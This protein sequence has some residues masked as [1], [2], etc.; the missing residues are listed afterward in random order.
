MALS[1]MNGQQV[2]DFAAATSQQVAGMSVSEATAALGGQVYGTNGLTTIYTFP[3]I[4]TKGGVPVTLEAQ[5]A[6]QMWDYFKIT[7]AA[8]IS[9][10]GTAA[11]G[12]SAWAQGVLF[13]DPALSGTLAG[14]GG[15]LAM[16]MP[17]AVTVM[18]PLL[19]VAIGSDIG[20]S[21]YRDNPVLWG[22][23]S[24]A[25]SDF[26]YNSKEVIA[27]VV[28]KDGQTYVSKAA[29]EALKQV[30]EQEGIGGD[31]GY[32][33]DI[34]YYVSNYDMPVPA[35][36]LL[37][38]ESSVYYWEHIPSPGVLLVPAE[39]GFY[40]V[41]TS[42]GYVEN[43]RTNKETGV[44]D[45]YSKNTLRAFTTLEGNPC[46]CVAS[47]TDLFGTVQNPYTNSGRRI[48]L[49]DLAQIVLY[50]T[51]V[52]GDYPVGTSS[53]G[54]NSVNYSQ[55]PTKPVLTGPDGSMEDYIPITL[56]IGDPTSTNDPAIQ[57]DPT[58]PVEPGQLD[59]YIAPVTIPESWPLFP[60]EVPY[61]TPDE[62]VAPQ[63]GS[64]PLYV[65]QPNL[66]PA[67]DPTLIPDVEP[68]KELPSNRQNPTSGGQSPD[69]IFPV[70]G[71][72]FPSWMPAGSD[73]PVPSGQPGFIQVYHP[74]PDKFIQ[75]GRWLWV[76]YADATIDKIWN[77]PFDGVIGA[78]ELY[79]SPAD[80][81]YSTIRCG[82]LDS[83][84]E[85]QV[86]RQRYT[87]INCG[88]M[89]IPEYWGNYLDYS[90]YSQA[91]IYL[92][93]IGIVPVEVD[94]IVGHAVNV[95]YHVDSY[96]GSCIAQVTVARE[97]YSNTL[98]QFSGNCSVEIPL[99]GASQAQI[100]A[101]L[102]TGNAY[103]NAANVSATMSTIGGIGSGL[104]SIINGFG[105]GAFS[106][107]PAG[108]AIGAISGFA[109]AA[110]SVIN[111][112]AGA[113]TQRAYGAAQHT[114]N[115]LSGKSI[116]Q[117]SG[118]FGSSHGAMGI[119][120]PYIIIRRPI[121]KVVSGYEK[122]Y[123]YPAHKQV[124]IGACTGFLRCREVHVISSLATD[125]EK[126]KIESLL[127]SGVYVTE[128]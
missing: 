120:K 13:G 21:L 32:S 6:S 89:V 48:I 110:G 88:S 127:T 8:A 77:N 114:A 19:G 63:S 83:G 17:A 128:E 51:P 7:G 55:L 66:N 33:T 108:M 101:A 93:F 86:V 16:S 10:I 15:L 9:S 64:D 43:Y 122:L 109:G 87:Q 85:T 97:G 35:T 25:L 70:P 69:P 2:I 117:H 105:G 99:A 24:D 14:S 123:G 49:R 58:A 124:I 118:S 62:K 82:F 11:A 67:T 18:A 45:L 98:Y 26:C 53:W 40:G 107:T 102:M 61:I 113:E 29:V 38:S 106:G 73:T 115:M 22:K 71:I 95:L 79:A 54:G 81:G 78:H 46:F 20:N 23:I 104:S 112:L 68:A 1:Y 44:R 41:S 30:F 42:A 3:G 111:G 36:S 59:P 47:S 4:S 5:Y 52:G 91:M 57:P 74:Q 121:Q 94:D 34:P 100:K 76:T 92:P 50:G 125:A 90:P 96:T 103:Q 12:A 27:V 60:E 80:D 31:E 116:V 65:P 84:V 28:D 56:P 126:A 119:K 39:N 72:P 37:I 75:F